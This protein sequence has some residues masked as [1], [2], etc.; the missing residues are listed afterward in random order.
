MRLAEVMG[1]IFE[2]Y[3]DRAAVGERAREFVRDPATGRTTARLLPRYEMTSYRQL[4]DRIMAVASEWHHHDEHP[5]RA[6]DRVALLGFTSR[7]YATLDLA[8]VHLGAVS[9]PLQTS[10]PTGQLAGI[11]AETEPVVVAASIERLAAATELALGAASVRRLVVF[12][13][14][15]VAEDQE[16]RFS[17]ARQ[18]LAEAGRGDVDVV[19]LSE[20]LYRGREL[21]AAPPYVPDDDEDPLAML[22]YTSGST[23]TPKG[24]MY[25]ERLARAMWGGAW[26]KLFAGT[27]VVTVNY[28]PMSHVAGHSSLK[29]ALV[30]GGST[31]F[32]ASS[33]LSTLF[34]DIALIRPTE[35]SLVPRVCELLHQRYQS[36]LHL[37]LD[38]G[39][40]PETAAAE[41]RAHL[42]EDVLG[43]QVTWASCA[44]APLSA[45]LNEFV[46]ELLG[47]TLHNVYGSTEAAGISVDGV[48]LRPPVTDYKLVDVPELGY[49][50]TDTPHPRGEL[51]LKSDV[52]VPG[53]YRQPELTA[54]LFDAEGY[55]RTGDVVA[56][57]APD[58]IR[59]VDRRK[60]VLKLSQGEFVATSR[61]EAIFA[62]APLVRQV[63]VHG[64]SERS[65]LLAV[66]VPTEDA[67]ARHGDDPAR[68]ERLLSESFRRIAKERGLNSYEIPRGLLLETEPFSQANGLLSD[69]RKSLWP[70]L[71]ERYGER[72]AELYDDIERRERQELIEL[73]RTGG[74]RP[75]LETVQ[76]ATRALLSGAVTPE[77]QFRELGGDS[78]AAVSLSELLRDTFGVP[79]P[80]DVIVSPAHD[81]RQLASYIEAR[82]GSAASR[83]TF[84]SVHGEGAVEVYA[85]DLTLDRFLDP[86][87]VAGARDLPLPRDEPR[88]V[89]LTGASGYL[90]RFLVLEWLERLE[91]AG[92]KLTV[93]VRGKDA[94]AARKRL[95]DA[96][97]EDSEPARLLSTAHDEQRLEV[98]AGD[99]AEPSLGLTATDWD[100]L[101][102]EVDLIVHAGAM[103]NHVLPYQHLFEANVVGTAELVRLALTTRLKS[104]TFLSSVAVA[105]A[106]PGTPLDEDS[107]I[108]EA[109]PAQPVDDGYAG[110]YATSK[111]AGEVLLREA[112]D[113]C[114]LPVTVFRSNMILA[115]RRYAGQLNVPDM[116]S[117]LLYSI[118]ATGVAPRSFYQGESPARA[119][120]DGLPVDFTAE[121]VVTLGSNTSGCHTFSLVNPH[122]DGVSLDT[123][124]TWLIEDGHPIERI[125]SYDDWLLRLESALR[126]LPEERRRH[127]VLPLLHGFR[128]PEPVVAGSALPSKRFQTA[129]HGGG[130]EIPQLSVELIRRY[131]ADLGALL[132]G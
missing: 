63:F 36:E 113:R 126:A 28:M 66:I 65:F 110:G 94:G 96:F 43:G 81:L 14:H 131:A 87:L 24:A 105:H 25:T 84:A 1:N 125:P 78:L 5:V 79:V 61:L 55:Y 111:W 20:V 12:D 116:F 119:H 86:E 47:L 127:S 50:R 124:V 120:Y 29:N 80:V 60:S 67:L 132:K 71:L 88:R 103:V 123:F 45:E 58:R 98:L 42:R 3:A 101:A 112:H 11:V 39:A 77:A 85:K 46:E 32:T 69:H 4:W 100:R 129:I 2:R 73:R 68:L 130:Q 52:V 83:P 31:C 21:A 38:E 27:E 35:L 17:S 108:R 19:A 18:R 64:S 34:E 7:D 51:L 92:G 6:G 41:V 82:L 40:A 44:S 59:I 49:F 72:L 22:I 9:V 48:L 8:C 114:G 33:D 62:A 97:G 53:Y 23:G 115:H 75:V 56:E 54:E 109:L 118:L 95:T 89:L 16:K 10:A 93:L 107:D 57:L 74:E 122:D 13:F 30:R 128:E 37:R 70:K 99:I 106:L 121:A 26:S 117:R 15:P 91:P 90:G 104:F 76:R 102:E